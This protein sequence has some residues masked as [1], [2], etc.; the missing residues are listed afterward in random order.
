MEVSE[1]NSSIGIK[2]SNVVDI[3]LNEVKLF[4]SIPPSKMAELQKRC[5]QLSVI[6]KYVANNNKPKLSEIYR[7]R[8]KPIRHLLLQFD[9]LSLIQGILH[10]QT[11]MNDDEIQQLVLPHSLHESVLQSLHDDKGHQRLQ[12]VIELLRTKVYWPSMFTDTDHWL[13]QCEQCHIAKG[14]YTE[15]KTQQG[16]LTANQP[17]E[18]LCIDF[19]KADP[20][21]GGKENILILTDAFSKFSQAFV[22]SSQKAIIVAK[23]LVEKW[24]SVFGV[25]AWIHSDQGR[26]F[27]NEIIS[28]LCKMYGIWQS[29]T[30]PYNP[31]GNTICECFNQTLFGLMRT[32]TE[33]QKPNWPTYVPSLVYAY[34][35]TPH[36]STGF[37][38]YELMFRHKAPMPCDDWLG[39]A[40]YKSTGFKSKTAWLNQQLSALIHANKQ[41][42]KYI[43]KTN[44]HNQSQTSGKELVIPIGNHVL[45]CDHP[46]GRN[47]IQNR[48][49][50][51]IYVVVGHHKEPNVY[52]IKLLSADKDTQ[53]KLV[54]HHQLFNLK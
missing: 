10:H 43:Q 49:K 53:P 8:S 23:L 14:D 34:N 48:F 37:Q 27:D 40:Q 51:D 3:E 50:S 32:L 24:F 33:E 44:K 38:P 22:T 17:L 52:Y 54:N 7:I 12:C 9:H 30:T 19:T 26:S 2:T 41:A 16:T 15:P 39:L 42:L 25:P 36:P 1:A 13:A 21:K 5:N 35:S 31:R 11:F 6:Y 46:E 20:S 18:L 29:T 4:H 45:L 47:K 28:H